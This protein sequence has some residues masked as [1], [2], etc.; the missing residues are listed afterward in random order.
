MPEPLVNLFDYERVAAQSLTQNAYGYYVGGADDE[1][2]LRENR[3]AFERIQLA[4]RMLVDVTERDTSTTLMGRQVSA[5]I[6]IAPMGIMKMA[7][8]DGEVGMAQAAAEVGIP[9]AVS[10]MATTRLEAVAESTT[11]PL[12]FQ[13]YVYKDREI[14]RNLVERAEASGY[15]ALMLTVDVAIAGNRE[16]DVRNRFTLPR[17]NAAGKCCGLRARKHDGTG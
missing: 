8:P 1:V 17:W 15:Q 14:T 4:P 6:V 9:M 12:W 3:A 13:L 5:P 7:H 2:T 11:T 16:R 10:T